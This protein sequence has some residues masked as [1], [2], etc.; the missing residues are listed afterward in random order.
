MATTKSIKKAGRPPR[1]KSSYRNEIQRL[2]KSLASKDE[3]IQELVSMIEGQAKKLHAY[4]FPTVK[5]RIKFLLKG[6]L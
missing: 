2:H 1:D 5:Q 6:E 3:S 4:S